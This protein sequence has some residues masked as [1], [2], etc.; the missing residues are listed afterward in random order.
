MG[1]PV[2]WTELKDLAMLS[3]LKTYSK[4]QKQ[5]RQPQASRQMRW[6]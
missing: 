3:S 2:G 6:L 4:L 1:Y 5:K